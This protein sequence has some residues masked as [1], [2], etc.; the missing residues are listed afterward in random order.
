MQTFTKK[1]E[2]TEG[3]VNNEAEGWDEPNNEG[4]KERRS[5]FCCSSRTD[6]I[7]R[8]VP[9]RSRSLSPSSQNQERA[10]SRQDLQDV[11]SIRAGGW[12]LLQRLLLFYVFFS[13]LT[14]LDS[15]D[16]KL[17]IQKIRRPVCFFGKKQ[18]CCFH[19]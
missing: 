9:L 3:K 17:F 13:K 10:R 19:I 18:K 7:V 15:S 14:L 6:E 1:E 2:R 12:S 16:H 4:R 8:V 11:D 5:Q